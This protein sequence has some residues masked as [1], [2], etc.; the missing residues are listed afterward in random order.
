MPIEQ[1]PSG[2][3]DLIKQHKEK[4]R[5]VKRNWQTS[6]ARS[7][8]TLPRKRTRQAAGQARAVPSLNRLAK[9]LPRYPQ[10]KTEFNRDP[11]RKHQGGNHAEHSKCV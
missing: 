8:P 3:P 10:T 1:K 2:N 9:L 4:Q 5:L 7:R 11:S 6:R